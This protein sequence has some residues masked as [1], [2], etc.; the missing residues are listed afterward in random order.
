MFLL[1][2]VGRKYGVSDDAVRKWIAGTRRRRS[3]A[4]LP[5][6]SPSGAMLLSGRWAS[7]YPCS[8]ASKVSEVHP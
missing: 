7:G 3:G 5:E 1:S 8:V 4:M 2:A 6:R